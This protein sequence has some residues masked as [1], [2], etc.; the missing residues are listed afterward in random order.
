MVTPLPCCVFFNVFVLN[1]LDPRLEL[2]WGHQA[3]G[4]F[5]DFVVYDT[6][7]KRKKRKD[8]LIE[9]W[10]IFR[11]IFSFYVYF[12]FIKRFIFAIDI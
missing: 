4:I 8:G 10:H 12:F 3:I 1:V 11:C 9:K 5:V 7:E 2:L 6:E